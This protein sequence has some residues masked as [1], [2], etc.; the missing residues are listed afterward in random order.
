MKTILLT[1]D[2]E[3]FLGVRNTSSGA[4]EDCLIEPSNW[5]LEVLSKHKITDA[6][7]FVDTLHLVKLKD[8][9]G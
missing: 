5:I 1:F 8:R 3:L 4:V 7:F 6:V 9:P 2:Y